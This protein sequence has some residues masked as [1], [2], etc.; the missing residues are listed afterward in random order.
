MRSVD[1]LGDQRELRVA[2]LADLEAVGG[3]NYRAPQYEEASDSTGCVRVAVDQKG[4]VR[5]VHF[6]SDWRADL[7]PQALGPALLEA[8]KNANSAMMNSLA[9]ASLAEE[10]RN[11]ADGDDEPQEPR[12]LPE[13]PEPDIAEIWRMLSDVEDVMYRADKLSRETAADRVRTISSP[14]GH[15]QGT[16]EGRALTRITA[17]LTLVDQA[18]NEQLRSAALELFRR[19]EELTG[20][21]NL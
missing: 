13:A 21:E 11:A 12:P 17:E 3:K 5:D 6:R 2:A 15:F 10:E 8:H 4:A 14:I 20:R 19:A 7:R 9:L 1:F 16:C 18:D